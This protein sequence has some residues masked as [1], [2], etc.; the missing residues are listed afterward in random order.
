MKRVWINKKKTRLVK[1]CNT[2]PFSIALN[3]TNNRLAG[4]WCRAS[5]K[6]TGIVTKTQ[7]AP[8][9]CELDGLND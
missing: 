1:N 3:S 8:K 5:N 2:C 7:D 6:L 9:W 4:F